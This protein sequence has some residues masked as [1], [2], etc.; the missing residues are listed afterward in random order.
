PLETENAQKTIETLSFPMWIPL[1]VEN[2]RDEYDL[3][4][5]G[6]LVPRL[7]VSAIAE[8]TKIERLVNWFRKTVLRKDPT[9][10]LKDILN[11]GDILLKAGDVDYP[12]YKQLRDITKLYKDKDLSLTVLRT[13]GEGNEQKVDLVV[14]PTIRL[15]DKHV[16]IGFNPG[17]DMNNPVVAQ[18][19]PAPGISGNA[20]DIPAGA[21]IVAVAD[22]PVENFFDIA[23]LLQTNAGRKIDIEYRFDN[24]NGKVSITVPEHEPVHA[25]AALAAGLPF[26]EFTRKYKASGP[27]EAVQMGLKKVGQFVY[28]NYITLARLIKGDLPSS[29][30]MGPVGIL[31]VSYQATAYSLDRYLYFLGLISSCLAVMNLLPLPVLDGGHIVLLIIEK[32][33]G[34]P[35]HEKIL[36]PIM[37]IGLALLLGLILWVSFNDVLRFLR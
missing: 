28:Q 20:H 9:A 24:T 14:R 8:P 15:G 13:D 30:L 23:S 26:A 34:K 11:V 18:V 22:Q 6:S 5:F 35:I 19:L 2:F 4:H 31:S 3:A 33:T 10:S 27:V 17:L 16:A 7:E 1:V 25:Q 21:T 29:A 32:I 36:A 37:Y 12:N